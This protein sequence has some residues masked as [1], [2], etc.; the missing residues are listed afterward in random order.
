MIVVDEAH[1]IFAV[2]LRLP[3]LVSGIR[4][5]RELFPDVP[6]LAL[7]ASA[8]P[9]VVADIAHRSPC[10]SPKLFSLSFARPNIS[11]L[12]AAHRRQKAAKMLQI[13]STMP[14]AE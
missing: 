9:E 14:G 10:A 5:L 13:F 12:V 2:G 4:R 1:C 11:F 8:T 7:T 6:V 3:P